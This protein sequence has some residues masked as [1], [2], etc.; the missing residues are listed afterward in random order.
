MKMELTIKLLPPYR[1]KGE[2]DEHTLRLKGEAI[3]LQQ[4]VRHLAREWK[5]T[6][7]FPLVDNKE[8]L[9]AEF[10]VNGKHASL[11]MVLKDGDQ[12]TIVPYI[13]GG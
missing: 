8:L 12:V 5:D 9:T 2:P 6:L 13:C 3:N 11:E 10:I 1:I 4:L 7:G